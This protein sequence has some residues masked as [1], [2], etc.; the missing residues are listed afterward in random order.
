MLG[1]LFV[2]VLPASDV[3][4]LRGSRLALAFA[5]DGAALLFGR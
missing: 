2:L 4:V 1:F 3:L 5:L